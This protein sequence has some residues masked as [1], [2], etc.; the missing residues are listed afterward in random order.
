MPDINTT[1]SPLVEP[2]VRISRIRLSRKLSPQAYADSCAAVLFRTLQT[3]F[4]IQQPHL[5]EAFV[6]AHTFRRSEGPLA[7]TPHVPREALSRVPIDLPISLSRISIPKVVCPSSQVLV[8]LLD[9]PWQRLETHP[10]AC[11]LSQLS[12]LPRQRL[13]RRDHVQVFRPAPFQV[14]VVPKRVSQKVQARSFF[15][16]VHHPRLLSVD[17]QSHPGLS[18][19]SASKIGS[20]MSIAA[21]CTTRSRTVGMPSGLS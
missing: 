14:Q 20:N 8:Q 9:Q 15:L 18:S 1:H 3:G 16:Q 5:F 11:H 13:R 19:K 4:Q 17:L 2:D 21:V 6:V 7:A 10:T 12:P